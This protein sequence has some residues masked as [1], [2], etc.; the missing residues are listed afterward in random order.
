MTDDGAQSVLITGVSGFIGTNLKGYLQSKGK[1]C[2]SGTTRDRRLH[3]KLQQE[4]CH[5]YSNDEILNNH[6][7]YDV[8]VHLAGKAHALKNVSDREAFFEANFNLTQRF[9]DHFVQ[10]KRARKF[11]FVS[12]TMVL[13][14]SSQDILD[15]SYKPNPATPYG[16]SKLM[17]EEYIRRHCPSDKMV[18]ILRPCMVHGPGNK[19]N[20]NM[21]YDYIS[22]GI[23]Y[24]FGAF[25]NKR[26][27]VSIE[28]LCFVIR[29]ILDREVD[30]GTYL[31]ADDE[32]TYTIELVQ[33]IAETSGVNVRI[34]AIPPILLKLLAKIG[35]I[36]PLPLN[37]ERLKKLTQD[38][39]VDNS[40]IKH[41]IG[42]G[43][44][45]STKDGLER[46]LRYFS[47][48]K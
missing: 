11:I 25:N 2:I 45:I 48:I 19:G 37:E 3:T 5:L 20:L 30:S 23:P 17:A 33:M 34:W 18:Y 21:L 31:I 1:Y 14:D 28:N 9:F 8:Y 35:N 39:L 38:Y 43:L 27:Y 29:E 12:T 47:D 36:T 7:E 4:I 24:P 42:R 15:E 10:D 13:T 41:A 44:P 40:K 26:N 32:P 46:T 16:E 22:K 6:K